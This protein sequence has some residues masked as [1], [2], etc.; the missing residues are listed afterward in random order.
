MDFFLA[1]GEEYY[2]FKPSMLDTQF[3]IQTSSLKMLF[4]CD[5]VIQCQTVMFNQFWMCVQSHNH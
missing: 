2:S 3:P 1:I 5:S 4:S